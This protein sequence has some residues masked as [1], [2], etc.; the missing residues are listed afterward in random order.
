VLI[1]IVAKFIMLSCAFIQNCLR[2][3]D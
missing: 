1:L 3:L 2:A